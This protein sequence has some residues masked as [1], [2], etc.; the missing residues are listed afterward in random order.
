MTITALPTKKEAALAKASRK[1]IASHISKNSPVQKIAFVQDDIKQESEAI[2]IE[3]NELW[4]V[5]KI[6]FYV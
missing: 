6:N 3:K 4:M 2:A 1:K 5:K